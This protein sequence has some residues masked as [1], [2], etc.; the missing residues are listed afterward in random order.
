MHFAYC[1]VATR[2]PTLTEAEGEKGATVL[3][4]QGEAEALERV[5]EAEALAVT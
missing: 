3:R 2:P 5:A 4:A 1:V